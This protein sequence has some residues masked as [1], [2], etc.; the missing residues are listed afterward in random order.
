MS[1]RRSFR[2][3]RLTSISRRLRYF[4]SRLVGSRLQKSQTV[5]M[6]EINGQHFKRIVLRDSFLAQ[7]IEQALENFGP[8]PHI[9]GFVMR[10]EHEIW[11]EFVAG[12]VPSEPSVDLVIAL[13]QFYAAV[14]RRAGSQVAIS[15][16]HWLSRVQRD[17]SFLG[18]VGV[19]SEA[20]CAA[21][22][23]RSGATA[24]Q[25]VLVGFD[26]N[27]PVTK[28]FA[29]TPAGIACG[30]DVEALVENQLV[31]LGVAKALMRWMEPYRDTFMRAYAEAEGPDFS[32]H[33]AFIELSQIAAYTKLMFLERKWPNVDPS[34]FDRFLDD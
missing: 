22:V 21:L 12:D 18:R 2:Q 32:S 10:Y 6:V 4:G 26:Y 13:A 31:G 27:D 8:S 15:D 11:V 7:Q 5:A 16:T 25:R 28:N 19:L 1:F 20:K 23:A 17:L 3:S 33:L 30:I 9:P 34:R 29:H 24:P 14:Y